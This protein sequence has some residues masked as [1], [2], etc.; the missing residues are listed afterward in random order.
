MK[1][2]KLRTTDIDVS[3]ICLETMTWSEENNE[4]D[5]FKQMDYAFDR[6]VN[7]FDIMEVYS[8]PPKGEAY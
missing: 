7:F 5:G 8:I 6:G 4:Y 1:Y 3:V 2:R